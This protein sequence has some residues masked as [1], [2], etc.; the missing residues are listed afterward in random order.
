MALHVQGRTH[1]GTAFKADDPFLQWDMANSGTWSIEWIKI[2]MQHVSVRNGILVQLLSSLRWHVDKGDSND[3][4][5]S[6]RSWTCIFVL[7]AL[8]LQL[9]KNLGIFW[10][11]HFEINLNGRMKFYYFLILDNFQLVLEINFQKTPTLTKP[12][13]S[14]NYRCCSDIL[15][16]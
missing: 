16:L 11:I 9:R 5:F 1:W 8:M 10:N 4:Y 14:L 6:S 7:D 13:I 2:A 12:E 15:K 3:Y